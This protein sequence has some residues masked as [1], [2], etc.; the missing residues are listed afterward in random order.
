MKP[1]SRQH[2]WCKGSGEPRLQDREASNFDADA[3][4]DKTLWR[5][6]AVRPRRGS[7]QSENADYATRMRT[8]RRSSVNIDSGTLGI[9]PSYGTE[10]PSRIAT[11]STET[12]Y[13]RS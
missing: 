2:I 9:M 13:V 3:G 1:T 6:A 12:A 7:A 5:T 8:C 11:A 4:D 10:K